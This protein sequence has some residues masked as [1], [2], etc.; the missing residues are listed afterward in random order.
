MH[1]ARVPGSRRAHRG[2]STTPSSPGCNYGRGAWPTYVRSAGSRSRLARSA[3]IMIFYTL[4]ASASSRCHRLQHRRSGS[5]VTAASARTWSTA[6]SDSAIE[7]L[8]YLANP[9]E[10]ASGCRRSH[11]RSP[12]IPC[13]PLSCGSAA[14]AATMSRLERFAAPEVGVENAGTLRGLLDR[15][16][17]PP[18]RRRRRRRGV[19]GGASLSSLFRNG[20][21]EIGDLLGVPLSPAWSGEDVGDQH[22][23]VDRQ[24]PV[25]TAQVP[26]ASGRTPAEGRSSGRGDEDGARRAQGD[27][28]LS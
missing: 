14:T 26:A 2:A 6:S 1:A 9:H 5:T 4:S 18:Q 23:P 19:D 27:S 17:Q 25:H 3:T 13:S 12:P 10:W 20:I 16:L 22:R 21:A 11:S 28:R 24:N 8:I 7:S 15:V